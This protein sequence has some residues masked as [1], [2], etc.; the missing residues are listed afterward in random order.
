VPEPES[1]RPRGDDQLGGEAVLELNLERD[2][3]A[4]P[5]LHLDEHGPRGDD[6]GALCRLIRPRWAARGCSAA[7]ASAGCLFLTHRQLDVERQRLKG[8]FRQQ[9]DVGRKRECRRVMAEPPLHRL[10]AGAAREQQ[11]GARVPERVEASPGAPTSCA[12]GVKCRRRRF[13]LSRGVPASEP[14]TRSSSPPHSASSRRARS[15]S[16]RSAFF[17]V[18]T[19]NVVHGDTEPSSGNIANKT[20]R[21]HGR[22]WIGLPVSGTIQFSSAHSQT[23]T[24]RGEPSLQNRHH[25]RLCTR[26]A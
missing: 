18:E 17:T 15:E 2:L 10:H 5:A 14:N 23:F 11:R 1:S 26:V 20:A 8:I 7:G 9:V 19:R 6:P 3:L 16:T 22:S 12:T 25:R 4:R 13:S 24:R 21:C